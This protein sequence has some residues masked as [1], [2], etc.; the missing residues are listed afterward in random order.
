MTRAPV[1]LS[2]Y[3]IA[4]RAASPFANR[5]L[6]WRA[7][8]G[9][10]DVERRGER[11]GVAGVARPEGPLVWVH[12]AS[13]GECMSL[14]PL[15][16]RLRAGGTHVLMTSGTV[17][18]ATLMAKRLPPGA[19][20][21]YAP[22][23]SPVF[24]QR[25]LAHW[26]PALALFAESELWPNLLAQT[27]RSGAALMLVNAR[28][29]ERSFQRWRRAPSII[30]SLLDNVDLVMAQSDED[31]FR[32]GALGAPQVL[33]CGNLKFDT[34]PP[35]ADAI[36]LAAMSASVAGRPVW[37]AASTHPGED[38]Y[39]LAAHRRIAERLPDI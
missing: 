2:A 29:S 6:D 19:I 10:E 25:F 34:P 12:G 20:H 31:A 4:A 27:K 35:P 32:Y 14:L 28:M 23:D 11:L 37:F 1:A 9:K 22:L 7:R 13:V 30:R 8:R 38:E 3:A 16:D 21:Q 26:R 24:A 5:F 17:T 33:N 39:I 18:S 36:K 15:V